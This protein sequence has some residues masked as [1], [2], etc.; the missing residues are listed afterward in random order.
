MTTNPLRWTSRLREMYGK[1]PYH[2]EAED[3][4]DALHLAAYNEVIRK[5]A[6]EFNLPLVDIRAAYPA[7]ATAHRTT[8]DKLLLDGMHPT[9]AGHQLVAELLVPVI[10]QQVR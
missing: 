2:P 10:R 4:F 6:K 9:D 8:V 1:P 3:G 7:F 5:L